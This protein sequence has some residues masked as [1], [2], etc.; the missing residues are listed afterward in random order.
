[1]TKLIFS[2]GVCFTALAL[3]VSSSKVNNKQGLSVSEV[4]TKEVF[5]RHLGVSKDQRAIDVIAKGGNSLLKSNFEMTSVDP[6]SSSQLKGFVEYDTWDGTNCNGTKT[7]IHAYQTDY[8]ALHASGS[9]SYKL[10]IDGEFPLVSFIYVFI[11]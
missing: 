5:Q 9:G 4:S 11:F 8:C 10:Q 7:S 3:C 2:I 1:M 6:T